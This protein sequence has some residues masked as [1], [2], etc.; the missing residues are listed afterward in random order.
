MGKPNHRNDLYGQ[1]ATRSLLAMSLAASL[2]AF[3]CTTNQNLGDGTPTRSGPDVRTAPTSGVTSGGET[4]VPPPMT[5]SY[6][7]TEP[8]PEVTP[9]TIR[10]AD[11]AVAIMA[12]HQAARGRYLG[13]V[14]PGLS[15]RGYVSQNIRTGAFVNP[16]L[17][18]NPQL[19]VNSSISSQPTPGISSGADGTSVDTG[20]VLTG[21]TTAAA[22]IAGTSTP[23]AAAIGLPPGA[24]AATGTLPTVA[25]SGIPT[26]T[27]ASAGTGR[28]TATAPTVSA[29]VP[30]PAAAST[31]GAGMALGSVSAPVRILRSI[32]GNVTVTNVQPSSTTRTGGRNQ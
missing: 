16:A 19:T 23:T 22:T 20:G 32:S 24:F 14:D 31:T 29:P 15:G 12:R 30:T 2:A 13:I 21:G 3:G 9:R 5:S 1:R 27:A 10:R 28:A 17:V 8:L 26:V 6:T 11:E 7:R 4:S 18:T 25:S